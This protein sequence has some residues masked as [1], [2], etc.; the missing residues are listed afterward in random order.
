MDLR[1]LFT[2]GWKIII[3]IVWV[4]FQNRIN[5]QYQSTEG[6]FYLWESGIRLHGGGGNW[7][8]LPPRRIWGVDDTFNVRIYIEPPPFADCLQHRLLYLFSAPWKMKSHSQAVEVDGATTCWCFRFIM[9]SHAMLLNL[10]LPCG[11]F[12]LDYIDRVSGF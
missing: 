10:Y 1:N 5:I 8:H 2:K 11:F 6:F 12:S 7:P 9:L 4:S 3:I